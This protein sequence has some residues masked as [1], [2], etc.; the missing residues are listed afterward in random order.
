MNDTANPVFPSSLSGWRLKLYTII[1]EADT[2]MGKRFDVVLLWSIGHPCR[3]QRHFEQ[4]GM[5]LYHP[6]YAGVRGTSGL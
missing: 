3:V 5:A 6:L 2:V 4:G 1:F